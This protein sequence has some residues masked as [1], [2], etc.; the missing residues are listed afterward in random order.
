METITLGP[1]QLAEL[2]TKTIPARM[3]LLITGP[4]G[5][6][7]SD[8]IDQSRLAVG[9]DLILSH[10]AISDPTDAKGLPWPEK[11]AKTATF[12]PFGDLAR[13]LAAEK[14]TVWDL[15]DLG[16]ATPAVQASFMQLLL[17]RSVNGHVLPDC[18]TF[19][20]ATNR[21]S[22][23]AW[24]SGI[25]EPVK[26]RFTM[27]VE[28]ETNLN[29][30]CEWAIKNGMAPELIAFLRFRPNLLHKLEATADLTNSPCPRTW[31]SVG[32][33]LKLKLRGHLELAAISGAVGEGAASEF[34][35]F[36]RVYREMPSIDGILLT[37][38]TAPIP[39]EPSALY[40]VSSAL[41]DRANAKNFPQISRYCER[42]VSKNH[43]E[44][45][46]LTVRD[47]IR[48]DS[49][50]TRTPEFIKMGNS[51]IGRLV[52]GEEE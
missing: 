38:D 39:K 26:S 43:A 40:A 21:R 27:I 18:V 42:L 25:L 24:V 14:L 48:R 2:L 12:L 30:W 10:P 41:G 44:F 49:K 19:I 1:K 17:A 31:A 32:K 7:K 3:P 46:V 4:P 33:I 35:A 13:A 15:D 16:Q 51:E 11:G 9:A 5:G 6:G 8:I 28:L 37:P 34:I 20:A 23:R 45:A 52:S 50:I 36:L 47:A 22:D 29:D